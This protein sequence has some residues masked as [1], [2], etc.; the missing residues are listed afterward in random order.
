[1]HGKANPKA[2]RRIASIAVGIE[3]GIMLARIL[4]LLAVCRFF[5]ECAAP[6]RDPRTGA[7]DSRAAFC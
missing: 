2:W 7:G 5:A 3:G 1:M 6:G 4:A